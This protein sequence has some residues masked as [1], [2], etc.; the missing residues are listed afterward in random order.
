MDLLRRDLP[1]LVRTIDGFS[2]DS[3]WSVVVRDD[4]CPGYFSQTSAR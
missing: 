2:V 3:L 1:M 4:N